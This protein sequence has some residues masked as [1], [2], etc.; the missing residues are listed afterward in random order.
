MSSPTSGSG[1][2]LMIAARCCGAGGDSSTKPPRSPGARSTVADHRMPDD[3][4][5][6][7][8][9]AHRP[10]GVAADHLRGGA[11]HDAGED[12]RSCMSRCSMAKLY[13]SERRAGRRRAVQSSA[14]VATC[15]RTSPSGSFGS[16]VSTVSGRARP[17]S[18]EHRRRPARQARGTSSARGRSR[19][20]DRCWE[21]SQGCSRP[22]DGGVSSGDEQGYFDSFPIRMRR[23]YSTASVRWFTGR[24]SGPRPDME[25]RTRVPSVVVDVARCRRQRVRRYRRSSP[26]G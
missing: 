11:R 5:H 16:Y 13:A 8:R 20:S 23:S 2:R 12:V 6:A 17:D 14:D 18:A 15:A 10:V 24:V 9:L 1:E 22:A 25:G 19:K 4:A 21:R 7:R 26:T 3:P